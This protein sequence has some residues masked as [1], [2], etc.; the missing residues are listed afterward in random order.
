MDAA[1]LREGCESEEPEPGNTPAG[2]GD[3]R[4]PTLTAHRVAISSFEEPMSIPSTSC[5][6]D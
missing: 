6:D 3:E 5:L 4:G 1:V 2:E